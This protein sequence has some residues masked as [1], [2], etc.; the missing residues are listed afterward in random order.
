MYK[1]FQNSHKMHKLVNKCIFLLA[2]Y[3]HIRHFRR[4]V[5][6]TKKDI[7]YN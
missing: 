2:E 7:K 1:F 5:L 6:D 4:A 3:A